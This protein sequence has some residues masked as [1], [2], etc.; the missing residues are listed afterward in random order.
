MMGAGNK[1]AT[2]VFEEY[3]ISS[4]VSISDANRGIR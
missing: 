2:R 1:V 4:L 3:L